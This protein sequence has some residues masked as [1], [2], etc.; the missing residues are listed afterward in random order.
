MNAWT[1]RAL[2]LLIF[3]VLCALVAVGSV[4][5][6]LWDRYEKGLQQFE[7]RSE[8]IDGVIR[9]GEAVDKR[10]SSAKEA[11]EPRL[12][13]HGPNAEN[14]IQQKLRD[15][16]SASGV[17]LVSSQAALEGAGEKKIARYRLTAS[18]T[19]GWSTVVRF[20][21]VLQ[22][23]NPP[24]WVRSVTLIREGLPTGPQNVRLTVQ[25]EAP[26]APGKGQP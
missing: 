13:S 18:M 26:L 24:L 21:E 20:M 19:G 3:I 2:A 12:Y 16:I 1:Q 22:T 6:V 10:L 5:S 17:T 9:A 8:R 14:E 23:H 7:S 15:L 4:Y 11:V 25:L